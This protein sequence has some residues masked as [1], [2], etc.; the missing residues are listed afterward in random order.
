MTKWQKGVGSVVT[1]A[2]LISGGTIWVGH[3]VQAGEDHSSLAEAQETQDSLVALTEAISSRIQL[4]DAATFERV[5]LCDEGLIVD[6][7]V[8][9]MARLKMKK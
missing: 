1:A 5:Q 9:R 2:A 3:L 8:C 4:E 7:V 6:K